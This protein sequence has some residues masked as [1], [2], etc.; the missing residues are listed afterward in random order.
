LYDENHPTIVDF[1]ED[2]DR[3]LIVKLYEFFFSLP[4]PNGLEDNIKEL[5]DKWYKKFC[6]LKAEAVGFEKNLTNKRKDYFK[7]IANEIASTARTVRIPA[8]G[9]ISDLQ[10]RDTVSLPKEV[11]IQFRKI[12]KYAGSG[13]F[14]TYLRAACE[15]AGIEVTEHG[16]SSIHQFEKDLAY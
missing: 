3:F 1:I 6:V 11:N 2:P 13:Y 7:N 4:A 10:Q 9:V 14:F 8:A 5:L 12:K 16:Y 15:R